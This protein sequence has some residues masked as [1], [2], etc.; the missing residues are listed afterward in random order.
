MPRAVFATLFVMLAALPACAGTQR[1]PVYDAQLRVE[2][3]PPSAVVVVNERFVGAAKVLAK[4]PVALTQ[5]HK[6]ISIEAVGYFPHDME[7][8]LP[9]GLTSISAKLRP[10]PK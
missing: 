3:E 10:V 2:A 5:G 9:A 6:R 8:D 7:L 4:R 1:G